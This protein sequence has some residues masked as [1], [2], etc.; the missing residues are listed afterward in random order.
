MPY[1]WTGHE[2]LIQG[3]AEPVFESDSERLGILKRLEMGNMM[4]KF[5]VKQRKPEQKTF[6]VGNKEFLSW[7]LAN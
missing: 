6:Q 1:T 5:M 2:C 3:I 4:L 7:H